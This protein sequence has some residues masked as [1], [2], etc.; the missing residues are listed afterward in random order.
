MSNLRNQIATKNAPPAS[1]AENPDA[2]A[3]ENR[4]ASADSAECFAAGDN[5]LGLIVNNGAA[6]FAFPY[7]HYLFCQTVDATGLAI[8]FATHRLLVVGEG[9]ETL[10]HELAAQRL[11]TLRVLPKRLLAQRKT[12]TWIDRIEVTELAEV[13]ST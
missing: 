11:T 7:T 1:P 6:L 12:A 2:S 10:V 8:R 3:S 4:A 9:L 13:A 5:A